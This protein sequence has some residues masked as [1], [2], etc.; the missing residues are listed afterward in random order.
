MRFAESNRNV[1]G[2][3]PSL[4]VGLHL[5][6]HYIHHA[7]RTHND[8]INMQTNSVIVIAT[9]TARTRITSYQKSNIYYGLLWRN[10]HTRIKDFTRLNARK[11]YAALQLIF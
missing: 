9:M 1:S 11:F 8:S 6:P 2:D 4:F 3:A 7:T 10:F 5:L